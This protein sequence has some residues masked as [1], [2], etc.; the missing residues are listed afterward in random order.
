MGENIQLKSVA[1]FALTGVILTAAMAIASSALAANVT[2]SISGV[3]NSDG[4]LYISLQTEE[5][6]MQEA[7][8]YA[9]KINK[10][11]AG[12][13]TVTFTDVNEGEYAIVVWHDI[14]GDTVFNRG[15][16]GIPLDGWA[17]SGDLSMDGPPS[18]QE[19]KFSVKAAT[20]VALEMVYPPQ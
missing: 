5:Q 3:Q 19:A 13:L 12:E 9:E 2:V 11:E 17:M 8:R 4:P 20:S 16:Y 1:R 10:P 7:A 15:D 18:F 6:F 14:N